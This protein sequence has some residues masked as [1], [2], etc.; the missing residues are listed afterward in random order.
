MEPYLSHVPD[1][2]CLGMGRTE[3]LMFAPVSWHTPSLLLVPC[4]QD[5]KH[6]PKRRNLT[7]LV[8]LP[9][10]TSGIP[11]GSLGAYVTRVSAQRYCLLPETSY[12]GL[13]LTDWAFV[14]SEILRPWEL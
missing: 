6:L 1:V 2:T 3:P 5:N 4:S 9:G 13:G 11:G 7:S 14:I 10:Q 8:C 12:A